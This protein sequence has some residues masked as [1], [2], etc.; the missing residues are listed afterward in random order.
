VFGRLT[1]QNASTSHSGTRRPGRPPAPVAATATSATADT[2][3]ADTDTV[4]TCSG[5]QVRSSR[6]LSWVPAISPAAPAPKT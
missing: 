3:A 4:R 5:V 6:A 2:L 1:P